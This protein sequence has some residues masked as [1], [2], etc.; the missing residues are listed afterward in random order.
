M[1]FNSFSF[2]AFLVVFL[3]GYWGTRGRVRLW[4]TLIAS[5]FFYACWNWRF[6]PLLWFS[7]VFE[8]QVAR[9]LDSLTD[10]T[11][12]KRLLAL[13]ITVNLSLLGI[14][15]YFNFFVDVARGVLSG[16]GL[17]VPPFVLHIVLPVGISF[18]TFQTMS[19]AIDVYRREVR[20]ENDL[21]QFATSVAMFVHLVAGPIVRARHLLP[22]LRRDRE[23][24]VEYATA[25]FEQAL[26][27]FFKKVAIADSLAPLCDN[28]FREPSLHDGTSLLLAVYFYAIQI[29]CDFSG[30]TDIALGCAK[31]LGYDLGVNFNRPYFSTSFSEFWTRWHISL[32]SWLRDY[33]YI[34]LGGNR[35]GRGRT[36]RNLMLTMML[37]GLWHG[38][39]WTFLVW[40]ALHGLYLV[41]QRLVG[42]S[43]ARAANAL[44]V[45][46]WLQQL[47]AGLLVFHLTCLAW[48][49]FRATSF[50]LAWSMIVGIATRTQLSF[51]Q[52][53]NRF[54]V[55]KDLVLIAALIAAEALS[56]RPVFER[57]RNSSVAR[58]AVAATLVWGIMLFGTFSGTAFIYFQF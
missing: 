11:A 19:Y 35:G 36:V 25:G 54:L 17:H 48:I 6:V 24:D 40:G 50:S 27:G 53:P 44:R 13:S 1:L 21:L 15:K 46:G 32:S 5:Y 2:L 23:L 34:P 14:F 43:L 16:I 39:S 12:R 26:W 8:Y 37:G 30:Y 4:L 52:V 28:W 22:Q 7:T 20:A 3:V 45:P 41:A 56:F 33:L 49:F 29:Y 55:A 10:Q 57:L 58:Y 31:M 18:Y 51:A 47:L 9:G 42:G 38:A